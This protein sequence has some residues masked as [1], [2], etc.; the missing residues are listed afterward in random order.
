VG[1]HSISFKN[2]EGKHTNNIGGTWGGC[3][4]IM[5]LRAKQWVSAKSLFW[6]YM[7]AKSPNK[8]KF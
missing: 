8:E 4:K 1:K 6:F 5:L 7:A 3:K 2:S